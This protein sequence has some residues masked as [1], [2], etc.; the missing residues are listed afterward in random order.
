M[1]LLSELRDEWNETVHLGVIERD[2]V[3]Y[4]E[5]LEPTAPVRVVSIVGQRMPIASTAMGK[6]FLS[7]LPDDEMARRAADQRLHPRTAHS[8][9]DLPRFMADLRASARRGYAID[10]RENQDEVI[11]VGSAVTDV[12]ARPIATISVSGPAYR[13]ESRIATIGESCAGA[14]A[15]ISAALGDAAHA[16]PTG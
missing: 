11:C 12:T 14:A 5:R 13:M 6:A 10:D 15:S 2:E 8:I 9:T 7:V 16:E 4:I 3:V 1:P